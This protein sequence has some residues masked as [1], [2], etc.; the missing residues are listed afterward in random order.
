MRQ[1][2]PSF[3]TLAHVALGRTLITLG[4]IN[5]GLGLRFSDNTRGGK[6][7]YGIVAGVMWITWMAVAVTKGRSKR[8]GENPGGEKMVDSHAG[9]Q[10]RVRSA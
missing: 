3:W 4:I 10:E 5:G 7:A 9:S 6:I 2:K 8:K 1:R